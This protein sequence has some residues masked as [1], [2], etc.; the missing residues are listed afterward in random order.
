MAV[1]LLCLRRV[2]LGSA[3]EDVCSRCVCELFLA[4]VPT[5][6]PRET[7]FCKLRAHLEPVQMPLSLGNSS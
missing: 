5:L 2:C 1:P 7:G 4:R 3:P 6:V